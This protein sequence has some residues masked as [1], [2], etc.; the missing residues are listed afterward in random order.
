M[1]E[2]KCSLPQTAD[3]PMFRTGGRNFR[4]TRGDGRGVRS[5]IPTSLVQSDCHCTGCTQFRTAENC[6][7]KRRAGV[8]AEIVLA[9]LSAIVQYPGIRVTSAHP[10]AIA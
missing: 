4:R 8:M 9:D 5:R 2:M 1:D 6:W 7:S 3:T 10:R